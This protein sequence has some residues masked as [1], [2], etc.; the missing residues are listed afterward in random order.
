MAAYMLTTVDNPYNPFTQFESWYAYDAGMGYNSCALLDRFIKSSDNLSEADQELAMNSAIDEILEINVFGVHTKVT[1][2][3]F[4][5]KEQR[6]A[7]N[8]K[9]P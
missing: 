1:K 6:K 2:E 9:L 8:L 3:G 5:T 4:L 7:A